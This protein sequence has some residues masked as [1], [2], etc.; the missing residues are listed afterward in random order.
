[1]PPSSLFETAS[2][3]FRGCARQTLPGLVSSLNSN[4]EVEC[5]VRAV[6]HSHVKG[7]VRSL[8]SSIC[9]EEEEVSK[10]GVSLFNSLRSQLGKPFSKYVVKAGGV[11]MLIDAVCFSPSPL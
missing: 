8:M 1:M 6:I 7:G 2:P 11:E 9:S 5:V 10:S 4:E 3:A